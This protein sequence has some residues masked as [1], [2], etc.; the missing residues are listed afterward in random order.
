[1]TASEA[2][3]IRDGSRSVPA[4][5]RTFGGSVNP[6]HDIVASWKAGEEKFRK[7]RQ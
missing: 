4:P 2:A 6:L 3:A 5:I 1:V 7:K